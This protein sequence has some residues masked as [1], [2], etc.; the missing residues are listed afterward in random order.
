MAAAQAD[1]SR[2]PE[3]LQRTRDVHG[4]YVAT[5]GKR[6]MQNIGRDKMPVGDAW[7]PSVFR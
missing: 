6:S 4:T 7:S 5:P 3:F 1:T 2:N